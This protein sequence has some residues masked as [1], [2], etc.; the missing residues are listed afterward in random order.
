MDIFAAVLAIAL[1]VE[2]L[3]EVCKRFV[4]QDAQPPVW[5]W[6]AVGCVLGVTICTLA[7]V[8]ALALLGVTL[9]APVVGYILTGVLVSRGASF[10]HDLWGKIKATPDTD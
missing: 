8:D 3:I 10:V 5:L 6:P 2:A 7:Q 4:P 1:L 9:S